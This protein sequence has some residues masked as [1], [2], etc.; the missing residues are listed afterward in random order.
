MT[1][2]AENATIKTAGGPINGGWG[3]YSNGTVGEYVCVQKTGTYTVVVRAYGS[4]LGGIWPLMALSVDGLVRLT[5][6]VSVNSREFKNYSFQ[7]E[8]TPG[9]HSVG[10]AFLNDGYN[11]GLEDRNLYL[12]KIEIHPPSGLEEPVLAREEE[13]AS[14]A[15]AREDAVLQGINEAIKENRMGSGTITVLDTKGNPVSGVSI[16]IELKQ[17]DFLFGGNI[18]MFDRFETEQKNIIYKTRFKEMF[19]YAT[20]PFYWAS[21]DPKYTYTDKLVA[22][23][24]E[25][26]I[27]MKGHPLLWDTA[28]G[29]PPWSNGQ[30]SMELQ[31][32]H[33]SEVMQRYK[34]TIEFWDVVNEPAHIPGIPIDNPYRWA[35]EASPQAYLIVNDYGVLFDAYPPFFDLLKTANR[36]GVPFQGI[37]IQAHEPLDMAFPLDQVQAILD[38]YASIGK[39]IRITEFTPQSNGKRVTGSPWRDVWTE[40]QQADYAEKFYRVCFAHPAVTAI[41]WWDLSDQGSWLEAGGMLR[42]DLT[43]KP[44]YE[45]LKKL[46][47]EEWRTSLSGTTDNL[48]RFQLSGFFG[49]YSVRL[50]INNISKE[51]VLQLGKG[52]KNEF[53][54]NLD[55]ARISPPTNVK[56]IR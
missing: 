11:G 55:Y 26:G 29:I 51:A 21:L 5:Q 17:H 25:N 46:I 40:A 42:K 20:L 16:T 43:S 38:M 13:W 28:A 8:F 36:N 23:C 7:V 4:A 47:H 34:G 24:R 30:P 9:V 32:A 52:E 6:R 19:N 31:Q 18:S 10:V 12:D 1:V 45:S 49:L 56:L 2:E 15:K 48:G 3:L 54:Y 22:W 44:V 53:T 50:Q 27:R 35:R 14:E 39:K 33:V 41:T 37:G